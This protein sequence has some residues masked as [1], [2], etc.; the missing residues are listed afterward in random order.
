VT[1]ALILVAHGA[2]DPRWRET[3]DRLE[4]LVRTRHHGPLALAFLEHMAPGLADAARAVADAGASRA[5]VVPLFLGTGG[6]LRRDLPVQLAEARE[7]AGIP[8][9]SVTAAGEDL[10]VLAALA[11]YCVAA[12]RS[13]D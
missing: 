8:L 3:F 11:D 5:V 10:V 4:T 9:E 1:T 2:R 6:H 7:A 12:A 13:A